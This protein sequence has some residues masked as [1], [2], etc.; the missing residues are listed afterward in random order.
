MSNTKMLMPHFV[1]VC[2][3]LM[4]VVRGAKLTKAPHVIFNVVDDWGY[5]CCARLPL[6]AIRP[7]H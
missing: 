1:V 5:V 3:L 4:T 2:G 7:A 6:T